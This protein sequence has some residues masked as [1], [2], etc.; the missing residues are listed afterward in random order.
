MDVSPFT[1]DKLAQTG[2]DLLED[3]TVGNKVSPVWAHSSQSTPPL[4]V[5]KPGADPRENLAEVNFH[6][7]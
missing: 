5:G 1:E 4:L 6:N 2:C 3:M 7:G